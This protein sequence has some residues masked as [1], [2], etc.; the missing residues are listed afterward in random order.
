MSATGKAARPKMSPPAIQ[1]GVRGINVRAP[2]KK[3]MPSKRRPFACMPCPV[4]RNV[5]IF[6]D[7]WSQA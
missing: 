5:R 6:R 4:K 7:I 1:I 2:T 3:Q